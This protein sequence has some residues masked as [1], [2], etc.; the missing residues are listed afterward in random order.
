MRGADV[1]QEELFVTRT[2]ADYVPQT[3]PLRMIREILNTALREMDAL[4]ESIY[5]DS[6]RYSIPPEWLLRG[7]VLQAL[8]GIRSERMLC[9]QLGYNRTI[10]PEPLPAVARHHA[11]CGG[12]AD[13]DRDGF[14]QAAVIEVDGIDGAQK[15][16]RQVIER[17]I[18]QR[19]NCR[20]RKGVT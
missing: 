2:T 3:H 12:G 15:I 8:Y 10:V 17:F 1:T 16:R 14:N 20:Y 7:L 9:E 18:R 19:G 5:A 13:P 4:F 6:G 11:A